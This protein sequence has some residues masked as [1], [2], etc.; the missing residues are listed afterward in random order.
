VWLLRQDITGAVSPNFRVWRSRSNA[1]WL[2]IAVVAAREWRTPVAP[3]ILGSVD[4]PPGGRAKLSG[5][6][7]LALPLLGSLALV[8]GS[9]F[10]DPRMPL[11]A[12]ARLFEWAIDM[13]TSR[14]AS[15]ECLASRV[16]EYGTH[17]SVDALPGK[18]ASEELSWRGLSAVPGM[19]ATLYDHLGSAAARDD[20]VD[21]VSRW[22]DDSGLLRLVGTANDRF[23]SGI[24]GILTRVS[25]AGGEQ[26]V[27]KAW[28]AYRHSP[29]LSQAAASMLDCFRMNRKELIGPNVGAGCARAGEV[30]ENGICLRLFGERCAVGNECLSSTCEAGRCCQSLGEA[31]AADQCCGTNLCIDGRCTPGAPSAA[32]TP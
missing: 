13:S 18:Y 8:F 24:L 16:I 2:T 32:G 10:A 11:S 21:G 25:R 5:R 1:G 12:P 28:A 9:F 30:C 27:L 31:C 4:V 20:Y 7:K 15:D 26:P 6:L 19:V 3:Q 29:R 17:A 22:T 23:Q 14:V